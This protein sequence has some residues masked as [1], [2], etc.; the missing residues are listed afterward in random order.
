MEKMI[1]ISWTKKITNSEVLMTLMR[2]GESMGAGTEWA[3]WT[4][5]HPRNNLGRH[6][7]H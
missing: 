1:R 4:Y 7:L 5:A 6:Y 3:G 2:V